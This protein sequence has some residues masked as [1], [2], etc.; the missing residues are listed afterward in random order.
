MKAP[1]IGSH[2]LLLRVTS[3]RVSLDARNSEWID[4]LLHVN[5]LETFLRQLPHI[6]FMGKKDTKIETSYQSF[7]KRL[8]ET[9][10]QKRMGL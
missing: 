6:S 10:K 7:T 8:T 1:D 9:Y 3:Y 5:A 2:I 4:L